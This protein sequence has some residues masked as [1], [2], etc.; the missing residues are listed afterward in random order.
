MNNSNFTLFFL[1]FHRSKR[2]LKGLSWA[3]YTPEKPIKF[4]EVQLINE[5]YPALLLPVFLLQNA[6]REKVYSLNKYIFLS[7]P[8]HL[9]S[10]YFIC[11]FRR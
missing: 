7:P 3:G 11:L 5:Q 10:I 9:I 4:S 8:P 2:A 1:V 6:M